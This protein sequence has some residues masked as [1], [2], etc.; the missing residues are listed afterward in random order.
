[1]S[2]LEQ[3]RRALAIFDAVAELDSAQ[4]ANALEAMC[5]NDD[6][7]RARVQALLDADAHAT[8]P[9]AGDASAWGS[10]LANDHADGDH[11]IGRAIGAWKIVGTIGRGG[12]GAVH[13][14]ERSDGAYAQQA[15][16]KLIRASADSPAA[17]ERFLRERQIL[18]GLQHP[19]IATL[20]DGGIS[21]DGEPY[22]V[23]ERI[24]GEPIDRWCDTRRLGLRERVVLFLQVLD[25]V[26]FAHRNLVVHRDLKPSNLL[27]DGDGRVKLLDFGIAKQLQGTEVT[28][29]H[30]RALTFE[31][32]SPEQ[33]HDAP[34]TTATDLWQLGVVL[35]RLLSGS[36]P[37]GLTRDTP[38]A[39]QL[40]QLE[41][42]PE[43]LTRSAAQ[44]SAEQAA[45]RGGLSPTSLSRALR[46]N[47]AEVVQ[48]CLRRDPD[49]RYA[50]ADA[51]G[52]DLRAWL[53]DRPIAAAPLSHGERGKLWLRRNRM[54]AASIAAVA[55][56]LL[57]G[58]GVALWQAREAREQARLAQR[59][60]AN[61][62][63]SL[64]FLT[65]ALGA[66]MPE[67]AMST[68][69]SVRDLLDH[70]R[71]QL[72]Q[73]TQLDPQVR[74]PSQRMLGHLYSSLGEPKIAADLF[75]AGLNN[76]QPQQK[77][78]ALALADDYEGYANALGALE[79]GQQSLKA[80]QRGA[81]LRRR[82]AP[83]DAEHELRALGSLG[84]GYYRTGDYK[85]AD[86]TWTQALAIGAALPKPPV[87]VVTNVYQGLGSMLDFNSETARAVK[88][89]NEG[90]AFA[91]RRQIPANSPLRVNLL[92]LKA[93]SLSH[94]GDPAAAEAVLRQ[95][96]GLQERAVGTRGSRMGTLYSDL[97]MVLNDL[98]RYRAAIDAMS[99]ADRLSTAAGQGPENIVIGLSNEA[100]VW[101]NAGD[102]RKALALFE[103]AQATLEQAGISAD[104]PVFRILARN[105]ARCLGLA[106]QHA[107][108]Q[109][110]LRALRQRARNVDGEDSAEYA[111]STWQ[112]V[113]VA[114]LMRDPVQGLPL[115]AEARLRWA[116]LVPETHVVFAHALRA[117]AAFASM[118]GDFAVA[119]R[120]QHEALARFEAAHVLP[121]D[122]AIA[123][124]EM[125]G[126]R[127]SR[128][129]GREA[130]ALL[131]QAL[132]VLREALLP[133]EV[134][135]VAAEALA[136]KLKL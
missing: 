45:L 113:T 39:K 40:Q 86:T 16:L 64:A 75:A 62:R 15:A 67:H 69:V 21:A 134:N 97:G 121:I 107:E 61:A 48:A 129:D 51:L 32:A 100:S 77:V 130:R 28:A 14:V 56:A 135:R 65:D 58:T 74:Q 10:A 127:L 118:Q 29:T 120:S 22:F 108:A 27:V 123:R 43:P 41:R 96:I 78:D 23:M 34:I 109:T 60:S 92:R 116:T 18:A 68:E 25:A 5:A 30:D 115:L 7:L 13:A 59:E 53:D 114:K 76:V 80:A 17:R 122:L 66:T 50:S 101:E 82:F 11:A 31:Y 42:E 117:Q 24:D 49:A 33:L 20:L 125:S 70:A 91:D 105:H 87:D 63:A 71:K 81:G 95:A 52:N 8:E 38:V 110:R 79:Q 19:N 35:H 128:G 89:A 72:D 54:L 4:R 26:G 90:L 131:Q 2:E 88:L 36:H 98:G 47:L 133:Q 136:K 3:K 124:A 85:R 93:T 46:G 37:F 6:A 12:M 1:M 106:G 73:R 119:E 84:F 112:A 102:Y 83:G 9:F 104:E 57:A 44:A 132:P 99:R 126:I 111:L 55:F 103:Q 94:D